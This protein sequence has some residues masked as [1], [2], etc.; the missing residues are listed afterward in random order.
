MLLKKN[1]RR[2]KRLLFPRKRN[3]E[4]PPASYRSVQLTTEGINAGDY[5]KYL[6]GGAGQWDQRGQF[7][8]DLLRS[9]G[10]TPTSK[11][12]DIGC[13]PLRAGRFF[14]EYLEADGYFGFDYNVSFIEA[15]RAII[16]EQG[17]VNK[18]PTRCPSSF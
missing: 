18:R 10:L 3:G 11:L 6:G 15:G 8:L 5:K 1:S 4:G 7:Q 14:I 13:G 9:I 2:L 16:D 17:L 12:A